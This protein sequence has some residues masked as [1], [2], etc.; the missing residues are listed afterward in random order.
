MRRQLFQAR[1]RA[2]SLQLEAAAHA[3]G[4]LALREE[5]ARLRAR[6]AE[7][8]PIAVAASLQLEAAAHARGVLALREEN[9]RQGKLLA[10]AEMVMGGAVRVLDLLRCNGV[11]PARFDRKGARC[12]CGR[13]A[14]IATLAEVRR[15][16][17]T[18]EP[19]A[20]DKQAVQ[21]AA[22]R[23]KHGFVICPEC[24]EEA[25]RANPYEKG[26]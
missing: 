25:A 16:I 9:A 21:P 11:C 6:L 14:A 26:G 1:E 18:E 19:P 15:R 20:S 24:V 2:A 23:C 8:E 5:N 3:R 22:E 10:D 4:V 12:Q 17:V 13:K 7:V